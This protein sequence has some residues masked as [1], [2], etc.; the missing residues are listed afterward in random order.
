MK[1]STSRV[2]KKTDKKQI[3]RNIVVSAIFSEENRSPIDWI[4]DVQDLLSI[5]KVEHI[6][7]IM[8]DRKLYAYCQECLD[9]MPIIIEKYKIKGW[10]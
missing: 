5:S 1:C 4:V 9:K 7:L 6:D 10:L 8:S 2:I 3:I